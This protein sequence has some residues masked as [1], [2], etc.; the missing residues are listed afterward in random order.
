M[1][2]NVEK[3]CALQLVGHPVVH[4]VNSQLHIQPLHHLVTG[5]KHGNSRNLFCLL[6]RQQHI[7]GITNTHHGML[8]T[9][10]LR[11][12]LCLD[13]GEHHQSHQCHQ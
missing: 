8:L 12:N 4:T 13:R 7:L 9:Q 6:H 11:Y 1:E 10:H 2:L 5:V 3:P